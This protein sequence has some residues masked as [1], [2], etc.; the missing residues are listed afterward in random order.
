MKHQL[1]NVLITG[2]RGPATLDMARQFARQGYKV[3]TV[4]TH[5][6]QYCLLSNAVRRN[7]IV[8]D[9]DVDEMAY[10]HAL[11]DIVKR[12]KIALI[13]PNYDEIYYIGRHKAVFEPYADVFCSDME[14][15]DRMNNK[16]KFM[17]FLETSG[18]HA[19][20]S[21]L[22]KTLEAYHEQ[23]NRGALEFP[24][25]V[26]SVYTAGGVQTFTVKSKEQALALNLKLPFLIQEFI[27]GKVYC[28]YSLAHE[29]KMNLHLT[30]EGQ[31][32]YRVNGAAICFQ[33]VDHPGIR[34]LVRAIVEKSG[35]TGQ[36]GF[37]I[38]EKPDGT[39]WP[40]E[41]NPRVTSGIHLLEARH[42][43]S[44][45]ITNPN[46]PFFE[47]K[48]PLQRQISRIAMFLVFLSNNQTGFKKWFKDFRNAKEVVFD[49]KDPMPSFFLPFIGMHYLG[50][51][52]KYKKMP[53]ENILL[54]KNWDLPEG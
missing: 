18:L 35:I 39:L 46:K 1:K 51:Y 30:Y 3:Y 22:V 49:W 11:E 40:I 4:E 54:S 28:T 32:A 43:V 15:I 37:D 31:H 7:F 2:G 17:R 34:E 38:I 8:P 47:L 24:H 21:T 10:I 12:F 9:P 14:T 42:N 36:V 25:I 41:C 53:E 6:V 13:V 44:E 29:G 50:K 16:Y 52:I 19:P 45:Y 33:A 5:R 26:K 27:P 23:I 20:K 48:E